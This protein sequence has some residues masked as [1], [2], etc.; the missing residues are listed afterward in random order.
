M[1]NNNMRVGQ[2]V[3]FSAA[4]VKQCGHSKDVAD[5]RGVIIESGMCNKNVVRVDT[6]GHIRTK[7]EV[8]SGASQLKTWSLFITASAEV[9]NEKL[10][11]L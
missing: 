4:V 10:G 1:I 2:G 8:R 11:V 5:M 9:K 3:M 6:G 7:T